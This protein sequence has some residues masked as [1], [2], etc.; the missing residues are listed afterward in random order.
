MLHQ[1]NCFRLKRVKYKAYR[2]VSVIRSSAPLNIASV[3]I[4]TV[5]AS[6]LEVTSATFCLVDRALVLEN[7][8]RI[9]L[10]SSVSKD[11]CH[12]RTPSRI[13]LKAA[14]SCN[15]IRLWCG[16]SKQNAVTYDNC[17]SDNHV[18]APM[19]ILLVENLSDDGLWE[20]HEHLD[21]DLDK[22]RVGEM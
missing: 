19:S 10:F 5:V 12:S 15:H 4:R 14:S 11:G 6:S 13:L 7:L 21:S 20:H 9:S 17:G 3:I 8:A 18:E 1:Y 16:S 22:Y 2:F